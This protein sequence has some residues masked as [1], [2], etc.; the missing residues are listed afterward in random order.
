MWVSR[1]T[2][3]VICIIAV[4]IAWD[5]N[6]IIFKLVSFA[7]AGFGATFGPAMLFSLFKK[8]TT[9]TAV[10]AGMISGG[11]MVFIWN[12]AIKPLGGIFGIY[13]LFPAF[14]LSC[15]VIAVVSAVTKK[16]S[17]DVLKEFDEVKEMVLE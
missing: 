16:P 11:A 8:S 6:S 9:K 7:W 12:L 10:L 5:E 1:I 4:I 3:A 17:D 13:E 2:I 15:I 14:I